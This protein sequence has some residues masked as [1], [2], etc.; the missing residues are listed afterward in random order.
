MREASAAMDYEAAASYR[1]KLAAIDAVLS[2]SALVLAEDVDADLFGIAEDELAATVQHFVIRGGRI[3]GVRAS[4]IEKE[5]DIEGGDLVDQ[6]L[7]RAYGDAAAA[8]IPRR[9]FVPVLPSDGEEL[10][11]WLR[12]RRGR[13]VTIQTAQR[14]RKAD[15]QRTANLNAQP[16]T[17]ETTI[18]PA[19]YADLAAGL[20]YVNIHTARFPGGEIRGQLRKRM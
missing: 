14:G 19:Q 16:V 6:V 10:E 7:Q 17:G 4:T 12:E 13:P 5:L 2:R 20:Y 11:E 9:V 1:D 8:D 18:T 15:L 3:R